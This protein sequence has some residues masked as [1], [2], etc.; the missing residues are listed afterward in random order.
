M[1]RGKSGHQRAGPLLTT[2]RRKPMESATETSLTWKQVRVKR[3]KP[4]PVQDQVGVS[5]CSLDGTRVGRLSVGANQR[6]DR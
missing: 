3:G 5:S 6:L 2:A 4:G 1:G